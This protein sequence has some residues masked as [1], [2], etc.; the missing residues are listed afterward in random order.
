MQQPTVTKSITASGVVGANC[1]SHTG[2][3]WLEIIKRKSYEQ[4][5]PLS[6]HQIKQDPE[7][8]QNEILRVLGTYSTY[9]R[10][11]KNLDY[12]GSKSSPKS[13]KAPAVP[14]KQPT[15]ESEGQKAA[16]PTARPRAKVKVDT[17][18][19]STEPAVK[20]RTKPK[21][22]LATSGETAAK[23]KSRSKSEP[24]PKPQA[25]DTGNVV[26]IAA[27]RAKAGKE[28]IS[29]SLGQGKAILPATNAQSASDGNTDQEA[30][31]AIFGVPKRGKAVHPGNCVI[32]S[33][34]TEEREELKLDPNEYKILSS[35]RRINLVDLSQCLHGVYGPLEVSKLKIFSRHIEA[36]I[37]EFESSGSMTPIGHFTVE[38]ALTSRYPTNYLISLFLYNADQVGYQNE[39]SILLTWNP[40]RQRIQIVEVTQVF[41]SKG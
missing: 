27:L 21:A 2:P 29:D 32:L 16:K 31:L 14:A 36:H 30:L 18:S 37:N 19:K 38:I 3:E 6:W 10:E 4:G 22:V 24:E 7:L 17:E 15:S 26:S 41:S 12:G 25:A 40:V 39:D 33:R 28:P 23:P 1:Q 35:G 8:D 11:L 5:R 20:P 13:A 34:F 9:E